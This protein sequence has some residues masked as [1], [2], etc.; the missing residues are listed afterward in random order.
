[1]FFD[2]LGRIV[3]VTSL[4]FTGDSIAAVWSVVN[5]DKLTHLGT[6][7]DVANAARLTNLATAKIANG[8]HS[9][10]CL[11]ELECHAQKPAR[12]A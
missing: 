9:F 12:P 1:M 7:S 4:H 10:E 3:S 6:V 11:V 5:L 8:T 2:D